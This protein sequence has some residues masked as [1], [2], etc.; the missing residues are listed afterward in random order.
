MPRGAAKERVD[1]WL[2]GLNSTII[3]FMNMDW[4]S[5]DIMSG[6]CRR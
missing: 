5:V 1:I 2:R 4:V 6:L 3:A